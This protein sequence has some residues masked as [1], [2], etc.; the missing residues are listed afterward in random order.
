MSRQ[1]TSTIR[2][3]QQPRSEL[4]SFWRQILPPNPKLYPTSKLLMEHTILVDLNYLE[5]VYTGRTA[6]KEA[7]MLSANA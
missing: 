1:M 4:R 3:V 6:S 7:M 5:G 2:V